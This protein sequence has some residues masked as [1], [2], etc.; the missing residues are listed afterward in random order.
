MNTR[1]RS[2]EPPRGGHFAA[3]EQPARFV[4]EVR[5]G[6][7]AITGDRLDEGR[8]WSGRRSRAGGGQD[9]RGLGTERRVVGSSG[10][11]GGVVLL[12]TRARKIRSGGR[13]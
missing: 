2:G 5:A 8:R 6:F 9:G 1:Q 10:R 13:R 7:Q 4:G 3:F 11:S 12:R